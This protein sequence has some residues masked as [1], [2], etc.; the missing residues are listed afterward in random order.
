LERFVPQYR[1]DA[2]EAAGQEML[3]E[4]PGAEVRLGAAVRG[5][6]VLLEERLP[7]ALERL[8]VFGARSE[9]GLLEV[10]ALDTELDDRTEL[11]HQILGE[12]EGRHYVRDVGA[13]TVQ[14]RLAVARGLRVGPVVGAVPPPV[15]VV[16]V[17]APRDA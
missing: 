3:L 16:L 2:V 17:R 7:L 9:L 6:P 13:V 15:E 14:D 12:V 8:R 11:L 5:L 10:D 4:Q 1:G